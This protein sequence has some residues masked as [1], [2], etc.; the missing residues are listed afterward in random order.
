MKIVAAQKIRDRIFACS[1]IT[2]AIPLF[3]YGLSSAGRGVRSE[4]LTKR[5]FG[6]LPSED[7]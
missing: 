2:F 5:S 6:M 1:D 4:G 3:S 7:S